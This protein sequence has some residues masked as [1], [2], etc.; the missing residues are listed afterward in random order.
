MKPYKLKIAPEALQEIQ[1][2][3]DYYNGCA[4]DLG[5]KFYLDLEEQFI[6]IKKN[7]FARTVRYA[8]VRFALLD[9][10]PYA[11]HFTIDEPSKTI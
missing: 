1:E 9:R 3:V 8:D 5:Q 11:A 7:P 10:F 6:K 2:A 4:K